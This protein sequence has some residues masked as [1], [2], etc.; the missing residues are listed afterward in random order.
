L[1]GDDNRLA[2]L[3]GVASGDDRAVAGIVV[4]TIINAAAIVARMA[5]F[6][7]VETALLKH[8]CLAGNSSH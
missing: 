5:A 4:A 6:A 8:I 7:S 2:S 3:G 1:A